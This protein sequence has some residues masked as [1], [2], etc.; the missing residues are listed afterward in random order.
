MSGLLGWKKILVN[1]ETIFKLNCTLTIVKAGDIKN[2]K[3]SLKK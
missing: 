2:F 3:T 1:F